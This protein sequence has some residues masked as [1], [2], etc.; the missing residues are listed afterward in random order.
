MR[1]E[2]LP[3][4]P[5]QESAWDYPRPPRLEPTARLLRVVVA[6]QVVAETRAGWRVLE[7]YHPPVY[8]FPPDEVDLARIRPAGGGSHCEWKGG[9]RYHD[10]V[11]AGAVRRQAAWSYPLPA[12]GFA[13]IRHHLAFYPGRADLCTVDGEPVTPQPGGFYGGWI[14]PDVVGPF[15][16]SPGTLHW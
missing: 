4:G 8:Y 1:A 9:A 3:P 2:R 16:G 13:A 7:T 5:G 12:P 15:K 6:G 10:V 11:V 14:T